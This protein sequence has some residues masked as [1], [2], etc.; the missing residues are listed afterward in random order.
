MI[1]AQIASTDGCF[2]QQSPRR[3]PAIPLP[4]LRLERGDLGHVGRTVDAAT[5]RRQEIIKTVKAMDDSPK[6][7]LRTLLRLL[8]EATGSDPAGLRLALDN[9]AALPLEVRRRSVSSRRM[10]FELLVATLAQGVDSGSLRPMNEQEVAAM[11][12]AALTGLQYRDIGGVEM[13]PAQAAELLEELI[14]FGI[15]QPADRQASNLDEALELLHEDLQIVERHARSGPGH[16]A[17][18]S[19]KPEA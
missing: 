11:V 10:L 12:I 19:P 17:N 6:A 7:R 3:R 2:V 13:S 16:H 9:H 18:D 5:L 4:L 14:V 8:G 15:S 1:H